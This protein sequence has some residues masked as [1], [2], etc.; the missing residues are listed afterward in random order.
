MDHRGWLSVYVACGH[1]PSWVAWSRMSPSQRSFTVVLKS[2]HHVLAWALLVTLIHLGCSCTASAQ[3]EQPTEVP[4]DDD[5]DGDVDDDFD[6]DLDGDDLALAE[7]G[8]AAAQAQ[9]DLEALGVD[10]LI[11]LES[12]IDRAIVQRAIAEAERPPDRG[13]A[14]VAIPVRAIER[15]TAADLNALSD[16][17]WRRLDC[18]HL[19]AITTAII[20]QIEPAKIELLSGAQAACFTTSQVDVMTGDQLRKL[21]EH[22]VVGD[23][24]LEALLSVLR[25]GVRIFGEAYSN[26]VNN[27]D[28]E[29]DPAAAI[30]LGAAVRTLDFSLTFSLRRGVD[31]QPATTARERGFSILNPSAQETS[32]TLRFD[33]AGHELLNEREGNIRI[34][35]YAGFDAG[36]PTWGLSLAPEDLT[37]PDAPLPERSVQ[38]GVFVM[39][40]AGGF[41]ARYSLKVGD[42]NYLELVPHVGVSF[43]HAN[44]LAE[45]NDDLAQLRAMDPR[46]GD[47]SFRQLAIGTN[48]NSWFGLDL[49]L[50]LR[51]NELVGEMSIPIV[52]Q[53][54]EGVARLTGPSLLINIYIQTGALFPL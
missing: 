53:G 2:C 33:W 37:D 1:R 49:S 10:R 4:V 15:M 38:A 31:V 32:A 16:A 25:P 23:Q 19:Q 8:Q 29:F 50:A 12:Q 21:A 14:P 35:F 46:V 27:E 24:R 45:A 18:D 47:G 26:V 34:G 52:F 48:Q 51:F 5:L 36:F 6:D 20:P 54:D 43:R 11:E 7:A 9:V 30:G 42:S 17:V 39:T 3:D 28:T 41:A 22:S 44:E 13:R 40:L